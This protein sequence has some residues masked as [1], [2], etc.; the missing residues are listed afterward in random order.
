MTRK[1]RVAAIAYDGLCTFEFGIA[2]EIFGLPRPE[3]EVPWYDFRAC[4]VDDGP[5]RATG[6]VS[7][8][9]SHGIEALAWADTIVVPGW[10]YGEGEA[11]PARLNNAIHAAHDRGARLVSI[12]SGVFVLAAAGVL[13]GRRATTHW[14]HVA[15]L[16]ALFPS[17]TVEP[18]LLY[19]DEGQVLTSAG[20]AAGLDLC[21]H[22][23]RCDHGPDVANSVARRLV[24]PTHRDGGQT[25]YIPKPVAEEGAAIG[26]VLDW[27]RG[28][29]DGNHTVA[30]MAARA[31]QSE[32]T[33]VRR[34]KDATGLP[35]HAWLTRERIGQARELLE[36]TGLNIDQIAAQ[37]GFVT[38]ETFRHHF[39][40]IMR[41][42]P[43]QY[44]KSFGEVA[45]AAAV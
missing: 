37:C 40:K 23:V 29:L 18:D 1:H 25:Q 43:S 6:G 26:P 45:S 10:R 30:T 33:F 7:L 2:V 28:N 13:D 22:I 15:R 11:V 32:R 8:N 5:A 27:L 24:L 31:G 42:S 36:T 3:L 44:R 4:S 17:V 34:F 12:C 16:N 19:V 35:P 14:R 21:I 20:S 38:P 39:R 9:V 41:T